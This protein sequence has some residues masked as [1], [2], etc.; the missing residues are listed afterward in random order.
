MSHYGN[1]YYILVGF[2]V[3]KACVII[4]ILSACLLLPIHMVI[5]NLLST[6]R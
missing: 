3:K 5:L 4:L 2:C 1:E 6:D